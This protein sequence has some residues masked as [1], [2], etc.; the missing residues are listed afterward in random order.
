M[1]TADRHRHAIDIVG[2]LVLNIILVL[3]C[4]TVL[5]RARGRWTLLPG[6]REPVAPSRTH[7]MFVICGWVVT[8]LL[9]SGAIQS[10]LGGAAGLIALVALVIAGRLLFRSAPWR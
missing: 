4:A 3:V 10:A 1:V 6:R 5:Y 2:W 7:S 8:V 9:I